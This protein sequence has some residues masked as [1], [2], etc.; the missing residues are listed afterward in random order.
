MS[1]KILDDGGPGRINT[2]QCR[3]M[4]E[5]FDDR[6]GTAATPITGQLLVSA[7]GTR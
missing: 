3:D 6:H 7:A 1:D 2:D 4:L 5:I